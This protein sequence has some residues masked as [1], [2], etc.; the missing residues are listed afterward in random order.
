MRKIFLSSAF[1]L[2]CAMIFNSSVTASS[3]SLHYVPDLGDGYTYDGEYISAGSALNGQPYFIKDSNAAGG[4]SLFLSYVTDKVDFYWVVS[5]VLGTWGNLF[6]NLPNENTFDTDPS[7]ADGRW[8]HTSSGSVLDN[9]Y[10]RMGNYMP[11]KPTLP[12][13][14]PGALILLG[15]GLLG[16]AGSS[17]KK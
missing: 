1:C 13:P 11:P 2:F 17:R 12:V 8:T 5:A 16:L 9:V 6:A 7:A 10:A 14:E 3:I 4:G 15:I